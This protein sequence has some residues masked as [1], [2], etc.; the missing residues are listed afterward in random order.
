MWLWGP[1][2]EGVREVEQNGL[3]LGIFPSATYSSVQLPLSEDTWILLY[4][5]GV[6]EAANPAEEEFGTTRFREFLLGCP[7]DS[8]TQFADRLVAELSSWVAPRPGTEAS[9]DVS[10]VALRVGA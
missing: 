5:D 1:A 7:S 6:S 4:T 8:A 3:F 9:D 2:I 10:F